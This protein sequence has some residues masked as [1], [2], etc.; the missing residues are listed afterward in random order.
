MA[1]NMPKPKKIV[2][3]FRVFTLVQY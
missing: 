2:L 3:R 1:Y